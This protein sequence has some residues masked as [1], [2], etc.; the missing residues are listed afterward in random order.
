LALV[1]IK[2]VVERAHAGLGAIG[3][4]K[5]DRPAAQKVAHYDAVG[6]TFADRDLIDPDHSGAWLA[7]ARQ[8]SC[9]VLL[10]ELLDRIP[11]EVELISNILDRRLSAAPA[12]K[13]GEPLSK[14]RVVGQ[15]IEPLAF[16]FATRPA[17]YASHGEFEKYSRV[18]AG[19]ISHATCRAI[20]PAVVLAAART[21]QRFFERRVSL[22]MR[23]LGLPKIPRT[24][25]SGRKPRN[26][27]ASHN[28]RFRFPGAA[29]RKPRPISSTTHMVETRQ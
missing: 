22:M 20:V 15:K 17:K 19:K 18:A 26:A 4:A 1:G 28:R 27:Y 3:A 5:P 6:M 25:P 29:I 8:L 12:D 9:H 21:A 13:V 7:G 10:I 2:P 11:I 24:V 23:A 16:H 14:M